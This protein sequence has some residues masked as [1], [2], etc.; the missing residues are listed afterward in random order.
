L[1][2]ILDYALCLALKKLLLF[3][4]RPLAESFESK[5]HDDELLNPIMACLSGLKYVPEIQ[6]LATE[7]LVFRAMVSL[8]EDSQNNLDGKVF[9][10]NRSI[11]NKH[12]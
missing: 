7:L 9:S 11:I 8:E 3:Q 5:L 4:K 2:G 12:N 10:I 6:R 1:Q